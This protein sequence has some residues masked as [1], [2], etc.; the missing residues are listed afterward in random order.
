MGKSLSSVEMISTISAEVAIFQLN[1]MQE[2]PNELHAIGEVEIFLPKGDNARIL[3]L[4]KALRILVATL[5]PPLVHDSHDSDRIIRR[6]AGTGLFSSLD[7]TCDCISFVTETNT[8]NWRSEVY[9][10]LKLGAQPCKGKSIFSS[11]PQSFAEAIGC[12]PL[13]LRRTRPV[14]RAGTGPDTRSSLYDLQQWGLSC[15][16]S[17]VPFLADHPH[18]IIR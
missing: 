12:S 6:T 14:G 11:S 7:Q 10:R 16:A 8:C 4:L 15:Q 5:S 13:N 9:C 17:I 1:K 3:R 18:A 2:C